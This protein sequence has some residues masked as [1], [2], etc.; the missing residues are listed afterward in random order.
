MRPLKTDLSIYNKFKFEKSPVGINYS[1]HKPEGIEKLDKQLGLCE[2]VKEAQERGKP[3][4]FTKENENCV[5]KMFLG[6]TVGDKPHRSDGGN[7][8]VKFGIFQEGRANLHMRTFIAMLDPG[9]VNY[10]VYTPLEKIK[11]EPDILV[12]LTKPSQAEILLRAMSYS[13]GEVYESRTTVVGWCSWFNIY[14]YVSGKV[15]YAPTGLSYGM[16]GRQVYPEGWILMSVPYQWLPTITEN[17]KEM[18]WHLPQLDYGREKYIEYDHRITQ[19]NQKEA[20]N[21]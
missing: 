20:E 17:L 9:S 16:K 6:M 12:F 19:E 3:F 1:F 5:G 13:T 15:N 21:P 14:P 7:L 4:Y 8:G 2:M 18:K 11:Y 10:V